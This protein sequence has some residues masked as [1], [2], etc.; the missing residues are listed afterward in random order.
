VTVAVAW[1]VSLLAWGAP[2]AQAGA[3]SASQA[4]PPKLVVVLVVD[5]MRGDYVVRYAHQWT[6]GLHRLV[7]DGAWFRR[8]A[9]PY[10]STV[11]CVGHATISTGALPAAHGIVGNSWFDRAAWRSVACADVPGTTLVSYGAPAS[12]GNGADRLLLPTL[13]DEMRAQLP[14]PVR[15]ATMSMKARTA[16]MLAG[17]RADAAS[18]FNAAAKGLATSSYYTKEPVPFV[19]AFVKANPIEAEL[20]APWTRSLPADRY[21]F[22]DDGPG[23]KPPS[24]WTK[25]FPHPAT[26]EV[27]AKDAWS[28]W[29]GSPRSDA[30]LGRLAAAAVDSLKLGQGA[31]IDYLGISFSALDLV[32]HDFGPESHEVQDVLIR[33]DETIGTLLAH[34][35]RKV[36][37]ANYVVAFSGDHGV[38]LIPENAAGRG[39]DA[40]RLRTG[41]IQKAAQ[42]ALQ[43]ALGAGEYRIRLQG[44]ELY[45]EPAVLERLRAT[46]FGTDAVV[47]A[48]RAVPGVAA[49]YFSGSLGADAAAGDRQA[50]AALA[51]HRPERSGDFVVF[52]RPHWF[53]V[54]D[55]GSAQ[56]GD[57]TSHGLPYAYDQHVPVILYGAG[58][59]KGEYLRAATPADIAPTLAF[60]TGVTLARPDGEVLIDAL[61]AR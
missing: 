56:P 2:F 33:L 4:K 7:S 31:G 42:E 28:A 58:I 14:G 32:G 52:P 5:Q 47:R 49:A 16:I 26:G 43:R 61:I 27:P 57:G 45:L 8:A 60:L 41:G 37:A 13:T 46:P 23:E 40:G 55:D 39:V 9:Y 34:L 38:A 20:A 19:S 6:R 59:K 29:E 18:W 53:F 36:G 3:G 15:V 50:R 44:S 10:A 25:T 17:R 21:L 12:G 54:T 1:G 30:Y 51:S 24:Y 48:L 35:D 11:T 22:V